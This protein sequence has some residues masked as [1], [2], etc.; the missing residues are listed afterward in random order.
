MGSVIIMPKKKQLSKEQAKNDLM[1]EVLE[2]KHD[3]IIFSVDE[4]AEF[5]RQDEERAEEGFDIDEDEY[6]ARN[7]KRRKWMSD[8]EAN[9]PEEFDRILTERQ[10]RVG[11][12]NKNEMIKAPKFSLWS[13]FK[14]KMSDIFGKKDATDI[15]LEKRS[16]QKE[17]RQQQKRDAEMNSYLSEATSSKD[18]KRRQKEIQS[19]FKNED[20]KRSYAVQNKIVSQKLAK[21]P[22]RKKDGAGQFGWQAKDWFFNTLFGKGI[23]SIRNL[24]AS[25]NNQIAVGKDRIRNR[26]DHDTAEMMAALQQVN[27]PNFVNEEEEEINEEIF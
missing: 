3:D 9:S 21:V 22:G 4:R 24:F 8:F 26:A 14:M 27:N 5:Q 6:E 12:Q 1:N 15:K 2:G 16:Q 17:M 20:K 25:K 18:R 23:T 11:E 10:K 13:R 19:I 7:E